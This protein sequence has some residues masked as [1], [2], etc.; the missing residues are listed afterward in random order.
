MSRATIRPG[1]PLTG[2]PPIHGLPHM[3]DVLLGYWEDASSLRIS[4]RTDPAQELRRR[5]LSNASVLGT[6]RGDGS[7]HAIA[8]LALIP[9][10]FD[11]FNQLW[12]ADELTKHTALASK[13]HA[14]LFTGTQRFRTDEFNRC[15]MGGVLRLCCGFELKPAQSCSN[16][17]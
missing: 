16:L 2:T 15:I 3:D 5:L 8:I 10:E 12:L 11:G 7:S 9:F 1:G 4:E 6:H 13:R 17:D 14:H